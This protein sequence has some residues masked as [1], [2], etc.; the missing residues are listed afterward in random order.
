MIGQICIAFIVATII[1]CLLFVFSFTKRWDTFRHRLRDLVKP[2]ILLSAAYSLLKS[3]DIILST[4]NVNGPIIF[5]WTGTIFAHVSIVV[6]IKGELFLLESNRYEPRHPGPPGINFDGSRLN[7]LVPRLE[8]ING[9]LYVAFLNKPLSIEQQYRLT[10]W[11]LHANRHGYEFPSTRSMLARWITCSRRKPN[12][13]YCF[14]LAEKTYQ[15][16]GLLDG[17]PKRSGYFSSAKTICSM[18]HKRLAG[19]FSFSPVYRV[20]CDIGSMRQTIIKHA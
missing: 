5:Y 20:F 6:S 19:G 16:I 15:K 13:Y 17:F 18:I 4:S 11:A 1:V 14:Q 7:P 9:T 12:S 3:G 10:K 8:T 2:G